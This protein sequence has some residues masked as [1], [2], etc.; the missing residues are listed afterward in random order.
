MC[1]LLLLE[2]RDSLRRERERGEK[3]REEKKIKGE[4]EKKEIREGNM[5]LDGQM[6]S[7]IKSK[8]FLDLS[9]KCFYDKS[10]Q[11]VGRERWNQF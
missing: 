2:E 1:F 9:W 3:E 6:Q 10:F 4:R 11:K 8:K 5:W 7:K